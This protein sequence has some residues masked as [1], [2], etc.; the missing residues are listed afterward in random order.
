[1]PKLRRVSRWVHLLPA[2]WVVNTALAFAGAFEK[3]E[4]P[5]SLEWTVAFLYYPYYPLFFL[6]EKLFWWFLTHSKIWVYAL[7]FLGGTAWSYVLS[8]TFVAGIRLVRR[9]FTKGEYAPI[10][11]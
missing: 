1:M 7:A 10:A 9:V 5:A 3:F 11:G 4:V 2:L 6:A 8:L